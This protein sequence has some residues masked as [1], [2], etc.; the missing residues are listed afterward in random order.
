MKTI[1]AIL[2]VL[3]VLGLGVGVYILVRPE[4]PEPPAGPEPAF[5]TNTGAAVYN[6]SASQGGYTP[7]FADSTVCADGVTV[8]QD[9]NSCP[10]I[11]R[12]SYQSGQGELLTYPTGNQLPPPVAY[13]PCNGGWQTAGHPCDPATAADPACA[14]NCGVDLTQF[15]IMACPP[16]GQGGECIEL[17][18]AP[19]A[20]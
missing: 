4:T 6:Q 9:P 3:L 19:K 20:P 7:K 17:Q 16:S 10:P 1:A 12:F 2:I 14:G 8:V 13:D 15:D 11:A 5:T 18:L